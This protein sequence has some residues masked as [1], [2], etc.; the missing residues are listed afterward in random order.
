MLFRFHLTEFLNRIDEIIIFS[1][2][3]L[4]QMYQIVDLQ[5]VEI[6]ERLLEHDLKI[7]LS[8]KAREWLAEEGYDPGFGARPLKRTLQKYIESP[9][10]VKLLSG[11][12]IEGD[13]VL[14]D[15]D[16]EEKAITFNKK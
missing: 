11:D 15:F 16:A 5:L 14:V 6:R 9:L 1:P 13:H 7:S 3:S 2:L 10:S 8:K 12:F 4:K